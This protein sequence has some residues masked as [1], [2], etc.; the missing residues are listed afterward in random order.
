MS[1]ASPVLQRLQRDVDEWAG[2]LDPDSAV[3]VLILGDIVYP[4]GL[5]P[6]ES[7]WF[8]HDTAVVMSQVRLVSGPEALRRGARA[9]FVA[10]N[11]DRGLRE[12]FAGAMRLLIGRDGGMHRSLV[13]TAL[14]AGQKSSNSFRKL[15][16][17]LP[18]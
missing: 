16:F 18:R 1:V 6:P 17:R 5:H 3:A 8:D 14:P 12:D 2:R 7:R 15:F 4:T 9:Y 13:A 11:H 10:G